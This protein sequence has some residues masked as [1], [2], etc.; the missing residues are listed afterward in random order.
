MIGYGSLKLETLLQRKNP[1]ISSSEKGSA[2][3]E[4]T[5]LDLKSAGL[6]FAFTAEKEI[7]SSIVLMNDSRYVRF[8]ATVSGYTEGEWGLRPI[9]FHEC[10]EAELKEFAPPISD[11]KLQ[12]EDIISSETRSLFCLDWENLDEELKMYGSWSSFN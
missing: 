12:L 5:E 1:T 8:M 6:K 4:S 9:D 3:D 10:T 11:S 2:L 7:G